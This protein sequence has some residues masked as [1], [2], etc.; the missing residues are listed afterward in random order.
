MSDRL[1]EQSDEPEPWTAEQVANLRADYAKVLAKLNPKPPCAG[2]A[3]LRAERDRWRIS[4][5]H[6]GAAM[7]GHRDRA[8]KAEAGCAALREALTDLLDDPDYQIAI[9]GN[10][11]A[12]DAMLKRARAAL[13]QSQ[14]DGVKP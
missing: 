9:G 13:A 12:V 8:D 1:T 4:S 10:P 7:V 11:H 2:C 5:N 14:P 6:Y 3:A